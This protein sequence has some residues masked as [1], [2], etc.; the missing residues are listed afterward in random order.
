MLQELILQTPWGVLE[1]LSV[2][3]LNRLLG[4]ALVTRRVEGFDRHDYGIVVLFQVDQVISSILC[5]VD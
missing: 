3:Y 1:E 4:A 2:S 5:G